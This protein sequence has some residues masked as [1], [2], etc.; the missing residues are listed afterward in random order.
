MTD[1]SRISREEKPA[2]SSHERTKANPDAPDIS[3]PKEVWKDSETTPSRKYNT[4]IARGG[5]RVADA[6]DV[7]QTGNPSPY[8][9][10]TQA[11]EVG[12]QN[13]T[14]DDGEA[15]EK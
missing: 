3:N 6:G 5:E 4:D 7:G 9:T 14:R 1:H 2:T 8:H 15:D 12:G 13:I 11:E 10:A